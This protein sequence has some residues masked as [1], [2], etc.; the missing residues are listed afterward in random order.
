[1]KIVSWQGYFFIIMVTFTIPFVSAKKLHVKGK[2]TFDKHV[3]TKQG[4]HVAGHLK[5]DKSAKFKDDVTIKETLTATDLV[6]LSC[7]YSLCV[8]TLS[9]TDLI[10]V[11][12]VDNLCV[13]ILSVAEETIGSLIVGCDLTVGCNISMN[14]SLS[15]SVGNI[16]KNGSV[17]MHNFGANNTFLG[18]NAGNF[19]MTGGDNVAIGTEAMLSNTSGTDNV[20]V[21]YQALSSNTEGSFNTAVGKFALQSNTTGIDNVSVGQNSLLFNTIG[22]QNTAVG[23]NTMLNNITGTANTVVGFIAL[24][25]N[26]T[27]S[28]NTSIGSSTMERNTTGSFNTAVGEAALFSNVTGSGNT[29]LGSDTLLF[30]TMGDNNVALG[31]AALANT[32]AGVNNI[33]VGF[34]AGVNL[35]NSESNNIDIGNTGVIGYNGIIRIGTDSTHVKTFVAGIRGVTTGV[36]DAIPVLI[37]STGQLGTA[38]STRRVKHNIQD[39]GNNSAAIYQLRPVTF[40]YNGDASETRQ[41]G[42]IA[43]EVA[44]VFPEMVV[45]DGNGQPETVQYH[46]LPVLL[47]NEIQKQQAFIKALAENFGKRI[48]ALEAHAH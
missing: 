37:D 16:I 14:D 27:G 1:M 19:T 35:N 43:E 44:E 38:S 45:L 34:F 39:M 42:L 3:H 40:A 36:A 5:V 2:A 29:A 15:P 41:Y 47:L 25:A 32:T 11:S 21:G 8:N 24:F 10:A 20:A 12:C 7:V 31:F 18:R 4:I 48:A 23:S 6:V 30:N 13:N 33:A 9:V 17:F 28:Y 46:V 26:T 22:T